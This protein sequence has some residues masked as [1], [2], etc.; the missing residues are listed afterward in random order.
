M[1]DYPTMI[2]PVNHIEPVPRRIRAFLA[3]EAVL[4]TT[5]ALYV[6]ERPEYPQYYIPL[7]DVHCDRLVREQD[8]QRTPRGTVEQYGLH[9]GEVYRP[10][11]AKLLTQSSVPRLSDTVR[12]EWTALDGWFE[13]DEQVCV[14]PRNPYVRVDALRSTRPIRVELDG[15]TLAESPSSVMVFETGLPTRYYL[16]RTDINWAHLVPT[17]TVTECPYKGRTSGYWSA[18]I[19]E[20]VHPDIAWAYDFPTG[21]TLPIAGKIAFYNERV[22]IL[23]DGRRLDRP[24]TRSVRTTR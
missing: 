19:G 2:T 4:D 8:G 20:R 22:D 7:R 11:A 17:D 3:G 18:R 12:F 21:Q 13:E 10:A 6:W 5:S 23:L 1:N 9:V 16:G 15:A 14:H 24:K